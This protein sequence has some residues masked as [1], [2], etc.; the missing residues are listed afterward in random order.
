MSIYGR[1]AGR[2]HGDDS[3]QELLCNDDGTYSMR[4]F[5]RDRDLDRDVTREAAGEWLDMIRHQGGTLYGAHSLLGAN[6]TSERITP[7]V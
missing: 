1:V 7:D 3:T 6:A 2:W 4:T 5:V